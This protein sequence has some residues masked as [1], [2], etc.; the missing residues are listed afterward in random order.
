[1]SRPQQREGPDV[2]LEDTF[3]IPWTDSQRQALDIRPTLPGLWRRL[4]QDVCAGCQY[5]LLRS[6]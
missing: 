5:L 3:G 4:R 6:G 2:R 1:M